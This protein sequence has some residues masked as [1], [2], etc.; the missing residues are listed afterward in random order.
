ML[1]DLEYQPC[2]PMRGT[3]VP[4]GVIVWRERLLTRPSYPLIV[5]AALRLGKAH[6]LLMAKPLC[7]GPD[8][9]SDFD[10]LTRLFVF[11]QR[12]KGLQA[13]QREAKTDLISLINR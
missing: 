3:E 9:I 5:E 1:R 11:A 7:S 6:S 12:Q 4:A 8:R 2:I 13:S 10:A